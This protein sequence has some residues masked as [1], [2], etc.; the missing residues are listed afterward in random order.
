MADTVEYALNRD[1]LLNGNVYPA[2]DEKREV[3]A[4]LVERDRAL[5]G[6][7]GPG[8]VPSPLAID[9][10]LPTAIP[11]AA[12]N[13]LEEE[14]VETFDG[15]LDLIEAGDLED[16]DGI[17][18]GRAEKVRRAVDQVREFHANEDGE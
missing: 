6:D 5:D 16:V 18:E 17:G 13:R 9:E 12:R 15:L 7:D 14:G 11:T 2:S 8:S 3:P 10:G 4:Q 1:Y